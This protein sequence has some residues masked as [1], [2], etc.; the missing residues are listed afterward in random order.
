MGTPPHHPAGAL[1]SGKY[2][3][4]L[5]MQTYGFWQ[6][7]IYPNATTNHTRD[8]VNIQCEPGC[9]Y[10]IID[11]PGEHNDLAKT[12]PEKLRELIGRWSELSATRYEAPSRQANTNLCEVY[13][14]AH[15]GFCG[16]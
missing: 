10:N 1:I 9:L 16:P 5:G 11:D 3:V 14:Q 2:K 13:A 12:L 7:P 8:D 4:V 15:E 6:G